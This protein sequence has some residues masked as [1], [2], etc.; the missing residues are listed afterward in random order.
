MS[1]NG[2]LMDPIPSNV[3]LKESIASYDDM[4]TND[5][6]IVRAYLDAVAAWKL[7]DAAAGDLIGVTSRSVRAWQDGQLAEPSEETL[8][9]MVMVAQIRTALNIC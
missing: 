3:D 6:R 1:F 5:Q 9:R 2:Y 8:A 4:P 7:D